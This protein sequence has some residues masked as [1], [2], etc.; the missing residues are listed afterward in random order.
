VAAGGHRIGGSADAHP[1]L[2]RSRSPRA[3]VKTVG[4]QDGTGSAGTLIDGGWP[5]PLVGDVVGDWVPGQPDGAGEP[6]PGGGCF[7]VGAVLGTGRVVGVGVV[8]P[9]V[10]GIAVRVV[11]GA[12]P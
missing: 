5:W 8:P 3:A 10:V 11:V 4:G 12:A 9:R 7:S 2:S 6:A 1:R